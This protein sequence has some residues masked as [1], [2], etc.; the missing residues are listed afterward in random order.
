MKQKQELISEAVLPEQ[1]PTLAEIVGAA[2]T[3]AAARRLLGGT[4]WASLEERRGRKRVVVNPY[5]IPRERPLLSDDVLEKIHH[6]A[7]VLTWAV[8]HSL[9]FV[10]LDIPTNHLGLSLTVTFDR[11]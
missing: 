5:I 1:K 11:C 7:E 9:P 3:L 4:G 8:N 2:E 6:A 10:A